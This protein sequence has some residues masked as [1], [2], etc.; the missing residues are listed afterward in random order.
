MAALV[1]LGLHLQ[2]T[3]GGSQVALGGSVDMCPHPNLGETKS[4]AQ[5]PLPV[6]VG[7]RILG[8]GVQSH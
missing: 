6:E 1:S 3:D 5:E 4:W 2:D 7:P 8:R